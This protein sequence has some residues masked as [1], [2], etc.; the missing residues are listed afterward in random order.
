MSHEISDTLDVATL[1]IVQQAL[2]GE[3]SSGEAV[4]RIRRAQRL[5]QVARYRV[6]IATYQTQDLG[7]ISRL[8]GLEL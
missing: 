5:A 1:V 3:I 7:R 2:K 4:I 6:P 8:L